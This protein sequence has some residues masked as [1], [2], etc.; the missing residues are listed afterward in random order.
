M[1]Y[2]MCNSIDYN[3]PTSI[4]RLTYHPPQ[5]YYT[6]LLGQ[7]PV[8]PK[9]QIKLIN[10][11]YYANHN[12]QTFQNN[13]IFTINFISSPGSGKTTLLTKLIKRL[14]N[15][16]QISVITADQHTQLDTHRIQKLG[17]QSIQVNTQTSSHLQAHM[18]KNAYQ[19]LEIKN[20]SFLFIENLG[21]LICPASCDLGENLKIVVLSVTEGEDKA[22]KYPAIFKNA[23][24]MI[25]NKIDLLPYVKFNIKT[26]TQHVQTI[27]PNLTII[28]LSATTGK[29]IS[30]FSQWLINKKDK[31]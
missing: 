12:R 26:C 29:H 5:A 30:Q 23:D 8:N 27:N 17:I 16:Y 13:N 2:I 22:L 9:G 18:I 15:Q 28:P 6:S 20:N 31:Y 3:T 7:L 4:N 1:E 21:N 25:I 19:S 24:L 11:A 10:N 14:K